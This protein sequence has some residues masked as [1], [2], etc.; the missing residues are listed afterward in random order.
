MVGAETGAVV[1]GGALAGVGAGAQDPSITVTRTSVTM[2]EL[3]FFMSFLLS[4]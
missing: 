3:D 2:N 4:N 1:A